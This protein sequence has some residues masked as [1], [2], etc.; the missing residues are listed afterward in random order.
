AYGYL[1]Q[2]W[3]YSS[4]PYWSHLAM[5]LPFIEQD[6]IA[7]QANI[8]TGA[9]TTAIINYEIKTFFCPS[10]GSPRSRNDLD[11]ESA[12]SYYGQGAVTN[13]KGINGSGW[14]KYGFN[15][16]SSFNSN[17]NYT[18][19]TGNANSFDKGRGMFFRSDWSSRRT[20]M[21]VTDGT[22]NTL[23]MGEDLPE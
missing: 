3:E 10:D 20:L 9:M 4:N 7:S 8:P 19:P 12:G 15:D 23:A 6:N 5:L 21:S 16:E 2:S 11:T 1:P 17:Y 18:D 22:S 14:G 13:Y